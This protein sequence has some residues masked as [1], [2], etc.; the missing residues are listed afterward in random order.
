M[1]TWGDI[2]EAGVPD[3]VKDK[4]VEIP[5]MYLHSTLSDFLLA[6]EDASRKVMPEWEDGSD[7][8]EDEDEDTVSD[9]DSPSSGSGTVME[10]GSDPEDCEEWTPRG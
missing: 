10:E 1:L 4:K 2:L 3:D 6:Q 7:V 5:Y 9:S 8:D